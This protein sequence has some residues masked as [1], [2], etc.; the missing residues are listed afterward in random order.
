MHLLKIYAVSAIAL[1]TILFTQLSI[2]QGAYEDELREHGSTLRSLMF[3]GEKLRPESQEAAEVIAKLFELSKRL[4]RLEEEAYSTAIKVQQ[5]TG[6]AEPVLYR[7]VAIAK[8]MDM[9]QQ[10]TAFYVKTRDRVMLVEANRIAQSARTL[11]EA[12]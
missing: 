4:H 2:A 11:L 9:A 3:Q 1:V 10:L 5:S 6:R 12:K 8:A 7:V